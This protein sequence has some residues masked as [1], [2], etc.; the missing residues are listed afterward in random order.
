MNTRRWRIYGILYFT[1]VF[2]MIP[3]LG[4]AYIDPSV[5]TY[6]IQAI[7]GVAVAAGAFFATYGRRMRKKWMKTLDI[8]GNESKIQETPL[9]IGREDLQELLAEKRKENECK[10]KNEKKEKNNNLGGRVITSLIIGFGFS[11]VISLRPIISFYISNESEFWFAFSDI[12]GNVLLLFALLALVVGLIHF[13]LPG[14][15]KVNIRLVFAVLVLAV[16]ICIFIQNHFMTSYL[17]VLTGEPIDWSRYSEWGAASLILWI[18]V[19]LVFIICMLLKPQGVKIIT[20]TLMALLFFTEVLVGGV[21]LLSNDHEEKAN[22]IFFSKSGLYEVSKKGNV[23]LLVSDTFEGTYMNEILEVY[24]EVRELLPEITYYDNMTGIGSM[25]YLSYP[26]FLSGKEFPMGYKER[27]GIANTLENEILIS[28]IHNNGWD[29][30][31]F[32]DFNPEPNIKGMIQNISDGR[33]IPTHEGSRAIVLQ[34]WKNTLFQS[35]PQQIKNKFMVDPNQYEIYKSTMT[36]AKAIPYTEDDIWFYNTLKEE[37]INAIDS[38][39]P[40]YELVQLWGLHDPTVVNEEFVKVEYDDSVS[41]H[42][43]KLKAGRAMLQLIRELLDQLEEQGIYDN[44]TVI[45]TADHGFNMRYY[46]V[47]L[48]KEAGRKPDGFRIDSTPLSLIEDF[49][50]LMIQITGGKTFSQAVEELNISSDRVRYAIDFRSLEGYAETTDRRTPVTI[51]GKAKE[52]S[53]YTYGNDEYLLDDNYAGRCQTNELFLDKGETKGTVAV[54]GLTKERAHGHTIVFDAFFNTEEARS[55]SLRIR[56]K[57][58]TENKQTICFRMEDEIIETITI[59]G[60]SEIE[61]D[62]DL[63][64]RNAKRWTV[65]MD[66]PNAEIRVEVEKVLPWVAFNSIDILNAAFMDEYN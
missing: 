32:S 24:P 21:D 8:D 30:S 5:T 33:P 29:I 15:G 66:M 46:P 28:A 63:P 4:F 17:P 14:K 18:G 57:N 3:S 22:N 51:I 56:L 64:K 58:I 65:Y 16:S 41:Q 35:A 12:I 54:Y 39:R 38:Q 61:K 36:M 40:K 10:K 48:V 20:Y 49:A 55:L 50:P 34:L 37:R 11:I 25:T 9:E 7:A 52:Q 23:I 13:L 42:E 1:F 2:V 6:A 60:L 59:N 26:I 53:S 45:M 31:Y 19:F 43:R 44:T 62:I 47:M 27:S